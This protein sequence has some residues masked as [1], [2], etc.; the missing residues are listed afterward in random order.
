MKSS[1][2]YRITPWVGR[3]IVAN[4]VVLLLLLT[5]FTS[6]EVVRALQFSPRTALTHPW[7]FV[8]YMFVHAGLLHLLAN[9]LML[10]VFGTAVEARMGSRNFLLYYLFCGVGAAVFSLLLAGL[11]PVGAFIGASGAVLGVAVAFATFWP[12]AELIVF[13]IP[14]PIKARTLVIGL[15][16]LDVVGSRLWPNDGIAHLAHVGGALFGYLFFR[17][18]SF[19]R[20]SNAPP[21]R[22][23]ERVVMVQ[24]GS[25][26]PERRTPVTP[27]RPRRHAD[28]DPVAA[29]VDRVLDKISEKGI[30]SL[31][32]AERRFLD[33]VSKKKQHD[34]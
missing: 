24:S 26:E 16:I 32:P 4:A 3:I 12:E 31:T 25:A 2:S 15:V 28:S 1:P 21:A 17:A 8:S 10:F 13:P 19:S 22:T 33:E 27:M 23:L 34:N 29:E 14:I 7:T 18:Q 5:L 11:M 9:M 30:S 6:P 20:R